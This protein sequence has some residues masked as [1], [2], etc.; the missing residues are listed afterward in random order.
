MRKNPSKRKPFSEWVMVYF[1]NT[2]ISETKILDLVKKRCPS[3]FIARDKEVK[4]GKTSI[5][6]MNP[7]LSAGDTLA[8]KITSDGSEKLVLD[9][10]DGWSCELPEKVNGTITVFA[11][12]SSEGSLGEYKLKFTS[13]TETADIVYHFVKRAK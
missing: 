8:L 11:L 5:T 7:Y 1:D 4:I 3:A 2:I 13:G 9:L 6:T 10:P 12:S